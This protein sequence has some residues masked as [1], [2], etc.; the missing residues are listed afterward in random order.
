MDFG[1]WVKSWKGS[2][3]E[4]GDEINRLSRDGMARAVSCFG[5]TFSGAKTSV[6]SDDVPTDNRSIRRSVP[7][8]GAGEGFP[9]VEDNDI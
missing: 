1:F 6:G 8:G 4:A 2:T 5:I 3:V 9:G 7:E